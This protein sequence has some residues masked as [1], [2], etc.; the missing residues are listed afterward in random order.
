VSSGAIYFG[1]LLDASRA[2]WCFLALERPPAGFSDRD[3]ND[4]DRLTA[5][6]DGL[7]L[8]YCEPGVDEAGEQIAC[9]SVGEQ[10][11]RP[12]TRL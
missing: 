7:P 12:A 2:Y 9:E 4:P 11:C 3:A 10:Q 5:N 6:L 8:R 1:L